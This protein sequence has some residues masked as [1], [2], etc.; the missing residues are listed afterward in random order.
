MGPAGIKHS[1]RSSPNGQAASTGDLNSPAHNEIKGLISGTVCCSATLGT[2]EYMAP[3]GRALW[4]LRAQ[5]TE[6]LS[7]QS[8]PSLQP[9]AN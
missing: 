3:I 5:A 1:N 9:E 6:G 2:E 7:L 4:P 8:V